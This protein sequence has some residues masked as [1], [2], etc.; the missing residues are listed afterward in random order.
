MLTVDSRGRN[1]RGHIE[2]RL[3]DAAGLNGELPLGA[4][5]T[6]ERRPGLRPRNEISDDSV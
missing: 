3:V 1:P 4:V 2:V 6:G 5:V